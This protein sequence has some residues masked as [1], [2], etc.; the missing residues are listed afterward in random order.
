MI[1]FGL[2]TWGPSYLAQARGLDLKQLGGA[3]FLIFGAGFLGSL[4]AGFLCDGLL[5]RGF[6][7]AAVL[8]T[9]LV[10]SGLALCGAFLLLP[11][12][13]GSGAAVA[14][15]AAACFML[16]WGSLYWSLPVLLAPGRAGL[17]GGLMNMAGSCG[18]IAVPVLAG[19]LLQWTGR[20]DPVLL[21][22]ACCA[23]L[24]ILGTLMIPLGSARGGAAA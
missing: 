14:L 19:S 1:T 11:H 22:F 10:L 13:S 12:V 6:A 3:T 2:L 8:R 16:C 20:Y 18:G 17:L 4:T 15:L 24:Y 5:A 21:M 7:R 23:G 9:M